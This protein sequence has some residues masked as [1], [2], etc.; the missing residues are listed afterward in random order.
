[1]SELFD[2]DP[3]AA[4]AEPPRSRRTRAL[5]ITAVVLVLAIFALSGF[6]SIYTDRLWFNSAGYGGVFTTMF[7]TR[8]VLFVVFGV[9]M[10]GAVAASV[11]LAYRFRPLFRAPSPEQSNLDRYRD[12]VTPIRVWLVVGV[13]VVIGA[14]AG[15]SG[16]GHWR[17]YLLWR[18]A[19]PFNTDDPY[20][21]KDIGFYVFSL[22]WFHFVTD[23][24]MATAVIALIA[25]V[26]VHYL[27]GGIRLQTPHDRFSGAAQVQL[28]VL[29]GIFVL[30]KG[31]DY[32][33]DRFDLVSQNNSLFTGMNY[34]ADNAVLPAKNILMGVALICAVLFF[35][36]VWRRTWQLPTVGLGLL[37]VCAVLLGMIWPAIVQQFQVK[38]SEPVKEAPY[39][40]ANIEATRAAYDLTDVEVEDYTPASTLPST[41]L[42]AL[43]DK[44]SSVPLVDPQVVQ[45]AFQQT[46]QV[47]NF[48]SVAPVLDVDR[49]EIDG[50]DR[51]LVLGAREL[52][53]AG[54]PDGDQNWSNLHTVYTHGNGL[55]AAY[56]NQRD[57]RNGDQIDTEADQ[58][59][60][61][62]IEWAQGTD[63]D[64]N[65]LQDATGGYE[66]R[67]YYGEQSP[68]YS[69]VGKA[70]E[71]D[72]DVE[73][74]Q[75][76]AGS[77][78]S[79]LTTYEGDGD[80]SVGGLFNQVM[81]AVKYGEPNFL[82]SGRVNDNS[83]ILF[84]RKPSE[85]VEKVAPW[86]TVDSDAYPA[87]VDGR[88]QW[89]VDGYTT[90]DRF[91]GSE[92]ESY[93]TM[94]NDALQQNTPLQA[95][96]TD[97][98]NYMRN[99]VK[100]TVDAYDG[101][102][103]LYA[104]NEDDPILNAWMDIF[105]GTVLPKSDMSADL[106]DHV[107]YP[108]D[109]FKAQRYQFARYHVTDASNWYQ[110]NDRWEVPVDPYNSAAFQAPYRLF[111]TDPAGGDASPAEEADPAFSL[112]S[113]YVPNGR[114]NLASFMSVDAD[115]SPSSDGYG[116]MRVLQL[117]NEQTSGP[118][119]VANEFA[120]DS[121]IADA[122]QAFTLSGATPQYGNVLT[123][124]INEGLMYVQP[125][126]AAR[127]ASDA[128]YPVLRYVL[129]KYGAD[130][131]YGAT[132]NDALSDLL[133]VSAGDATTGGTSSGQGGGNG[134]GQNGGQEGGGATG[135]VEQQIA[136]TLSQ[137]QTALQAADAALA[138]QDL[139]E[140]QRQVDLAQ[141]RL[142]QALALRAQQ[143]SGGGDSNPS[144]GSTQSP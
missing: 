87:V 24:V 108:E 138:D 62:G 15:T 8:V 16:M 128:S 127:E 54:I 90:T 122:L 133:G 111:V 19:Q 83:Q 130:I 61:A 1:M 13:A 76:T 126:Y 69:I 121:G 46:Q 99:A 64:E 14:F 12:V 144:D 77:D 51:A 2:D 92:R 45:P 137:V 29:L 100:A 80:A 97:E 125:V 52:D 65:D 117:P 22:P 28:S 105:P 107:R 74:N 140:Y 95:L 124:P 102:V 106:L 26:V 7:W 57:R 40:A 75:P 25:A 70:D 6:A 81:F 93:R 32:Y 20:F 71:S 38:P 31:V 55:I 101:T 59:N 119:Q 123:F 4:A 129:V 27:F 30:A 18:N 67:I 49:Y 85:R 17:T 131:G 56:A 113:V 73:I 116:K 96:P 36:N 109:L 79:T 43:D 33:L 5:L 88:I 53:Q 143:S 84:D 112:T 110:G 39:I 98:I 136:R 91:P 114:D 82:L 104:W 34:T 135:T 10:G 35:L 9:V 41:M 72:T 21:N 50:V 42:A 68:D 120:S 44:T 48:Y 63:A 78:A 23:F 134:G 11:Y 3:R 141:T 142:E 132:F 37:V 86:L 103:K 139:A 58:T 94:I 89:I 47:R 60:T 115:A 66:D 118:G